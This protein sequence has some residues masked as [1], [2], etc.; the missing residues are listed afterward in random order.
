[1]WCPVSTYC[2]CSRLHLYAEET[3]AAM[4]VHFKLIDLSGTKYDVYKNGLGKPE[5]GK[6]VEGIRQTAEEAFAIRSATLAACERTVELTSEVGAKTGKE[7][8]KTITA[9]DL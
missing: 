6:K 9:M 5:A 8:L 1:M 2:E 4:A 7:W 3:F